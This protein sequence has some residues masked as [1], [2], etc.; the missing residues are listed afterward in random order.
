MSPHDYR[1]KQVNRMTSL[2]LSGQ[3]TQFA[4]RF[5][6]VWIIDEVQS[7]TSVVIFCYWRWRIRLLVAFSCPAPLDSELGDTLRAYCGAAGAKGFA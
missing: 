7:G 3:P 4:A 2:S 6:A 1:I 5:P